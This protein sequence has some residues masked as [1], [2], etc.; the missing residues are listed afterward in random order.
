MLGW[1]TL[2]IAGEFTGSPHLKEFRF[3]F[4]QARDALMV[5]ATLMCFLLQFLAVCGCKIAL[6][7]TTPNYCI[8]IYGTV[9][10]FFM[11]V[12][13]LSEGAYLKQIGVVSDPQIDGYCNMTREELKEEATNSWVRSYF[14]MAKRFDTIS[15][16]ISAD[17]MC[18]QRCPC[19]EYEFRRDH[20]M[21]GNT[22]V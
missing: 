9:L 21:R 13:L 19:L 6:D 7:R 12:P 5:F 4:E 3:E 17:H 8:V 22:K 1:I 16:E 18:T 15:E 2:G 11:A 20:Q 14:L 10:F